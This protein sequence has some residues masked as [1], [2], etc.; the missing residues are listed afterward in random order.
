MFLLQIYTLSSYIC[1]EMKSL[2]QAL[3]AI[4]ILLLGPHGL[5]VI[6]TGLLLHSCESAVQ[7]PPLIALL[8]GLTLW[9]TTL[10]ALR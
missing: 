9:C 7:N 5:S 2:Q 10:A 4:S 8:D 3:K 1:M 6:N